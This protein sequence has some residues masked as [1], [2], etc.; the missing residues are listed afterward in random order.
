MHSMWAC[1][2]THGH[3]AQQAYC[4]PGPQL[5]THSLKLLRQLRPLLQHHLQVCPVEAVQLHVAAG[6]HCCAA[7]LAQQAA[8][9][10]KVLAWVQV[11]Q[12]PVGSKALA[13][14]LA[15]AFG[16]PLWCAFDQI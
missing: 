2:M 7:L 6:H 16:C 10:A 11:A 1:M 12:V 15:Q 13:L 4:T 5:P 8:V 9:L 14:H 3:S